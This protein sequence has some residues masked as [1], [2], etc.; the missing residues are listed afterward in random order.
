MLAADLGA[1]TVFRLDP[2]DLSVKGVVP[3]P[4]GTG[5]RHITRHPSLQSCVYVLGELA[6]DMHVFHIG[7]DGEWQE[8]QSFSLLP[9]FAT[10]DAIE[11]SRHG[12]AQPSIAAEVQIT[13]DGATL[14]ASVR[15]LPPC[16]VENDILFIAPVD[17]ASG[18]VDIAQA[19]HVDLKGTCPRHFEISPD[20]D[21][22]A[23][24]LQDSNRVDIYKMN[25]RQLELVASID[26]EAPTCV[27]WL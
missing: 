15:Y 7:N 13:P 9:P 20:G 23:L 14:V 6:A 26:I 24:T 22:L 11:Q 2:L 16:D 25:G 3:L 21:Y 8:T 19:Q 5:P 4:P 10:R 17:T 1:D 12:Y 18:H 27:R